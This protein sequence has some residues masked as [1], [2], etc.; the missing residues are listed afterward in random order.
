MKYI[1]KGKLS[2]ITFNNS[3]QQWWKKRILFF[4]LTSYYK[5]I[6][7]KKKKLRRGWALLNVNYMEVK[8]EESS[9]KNTNLKYV[10]NIWS[11]IKR[12]ELHK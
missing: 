7:V 12:N 10:L 11:L 6:I 1:P 5:D 4:N 3:A 2:A 8:V 9:P